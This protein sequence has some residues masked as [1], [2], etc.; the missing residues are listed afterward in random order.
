MFGDRM[1]EEITVITKQLID[2]LEN[3]KE[4]FFKEEADTG[5]KIPFEIIKEETMPVFLLLEAW[6]QQTA[7]L[8]KARKVNLHPHQVQSTTENMEMLLMHS[9]FKDVRKRKYM[10]T[11]KSSLYIFN[12]LLGE[13]QHEA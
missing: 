1:M 4:V 12:Q 3:L 13:I 7:L 11:Y 2:H 10:E 5:V 9:Y 6:E 8:V